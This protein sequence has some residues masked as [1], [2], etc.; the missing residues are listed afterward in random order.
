VKLHTATAR[1]SEYAMHT[2]EFLSNEK[3]F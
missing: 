3:S 2:P 1:D